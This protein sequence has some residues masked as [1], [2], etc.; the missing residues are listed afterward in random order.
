MPD[1]FLSP[2][3][4]AGLSAKL[5]DPFFARLWEEN[6]LAMAAYDALCGESI[7]DL[8]CNLSD[9]RS[10]RTNAMHYRA[11]KGRLIRSAV[12]LHI[13]GR[14]EA[15]DFA[16][17]TIDFL[18]Q[19]ELWRASAKGCR[20]DHFDLK[21]GDLLYDAVFTLEAFRP[22][23]DAPRRERLIHLMIEEG[24]AAY[25]RGWEAGEWWRAA[26]FN[27]GTA[28]NGNAGLAALALAE[29]AP[30]LSA[31]VLGL[32]RAG[33]AVVIAELPLD[34][35][36]TEGS[37]YQTTTLG[38]LS[39]FV[40]ALHRTTGD[41]L[42][43]LDNP[44][45][46][47]AFD[48]RPA[49]LAPDGNLFNFSNCSSLPRI[50]GLPH[51]YW[52]AQ[53]FNRPQWTAFADALGKP[54]DDTNTVFY[55]VE[56]FLYRPAHPALEPPAPQPPL[57]H[58]RGLD[59]AVWRGPEA[60]LGWRCGN[61]GGNHNNLDLGHFIFGRGG[62]RFL[63]DPGYGASRTSQ[64][65]AVTIRGKDQA[66]LATARILICRE[67]PTGAYLA[68]DLRECFPHVL[69]AHFRHLIFHGEHLFVV[70]A[71]RGRHGR[72]VSA[73]YHFQTDFG[74]ARTDRGARIM[75]QHGSLSLISL[76]SHCP[77]RLSSWSHA[78]IPLTAITFHCQ[79]DRSEEV[80]IFLLSSDPAAAP[81]LAL[82][83]ATG[84]AVIRDGGSA[85]AYSVW[86]PQAG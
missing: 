50:W 55:D 43:L 70:D 61:N 13:S 28:T 82:D 3:E 15:W 85:A 32:A 72:R 39:D 81:S 67:T 51:V 86:A 60:W 75:G 34:G 8:P 16:S 33:L 44:R 84:E 65:N 12:A 31:Q 45:L 79:P 77:P 69:E 23:L 41:H 54:W 42:G 17:R 62:D 6:Q 56:A 80:S 71:I 19:P 4:W 37:M 58:F 21:M 9:A 30:E 57:R 76:T 11:I 20:I 29:T 49:E 26:E 66:D 83:A 53:Q 68:C 14:E 73:E 22:W 47:E 48:S 40:F 64:H 59:W 10:Q 74:V 78:G 38:H 46:F 2:A 52:W 18:L 1:L 24:L 35:W 27:W 25:L 36:W 5:S 63:V 7:L